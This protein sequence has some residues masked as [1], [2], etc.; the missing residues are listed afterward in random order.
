MHSWRR[1][2]TGILT[3][4]IAV[5]AASAL[6]GFVAFDLSLWAALLVYVVSGVAATLFAA[7]RRFRCIERQEMRDTGQRSVQ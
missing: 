4:G 6:I 2:L 7:W 5:A 3:I 1:L